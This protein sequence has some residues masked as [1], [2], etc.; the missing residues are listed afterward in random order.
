M[1]K[2]QQVID[3]AKRRIAKV[4]ETESTVKEMKV[5]SS[6]LGGFAKNFL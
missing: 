4:Q 3:K 2:K 1:A 5:A 6:G